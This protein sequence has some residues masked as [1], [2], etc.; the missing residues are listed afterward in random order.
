MEIAFGVLGG[1]G[2]FLYGMNLMGTGLQKAAGER[3]KKLIEILTNN[4][5][6]G[7]LVCTLVTMIIQ[8]SSATTV[9]VVGFVNA[10]LMTLSQAIGVIMG[11]N[12][13]T[14]VTAQLVAFK[15]TD[16]APIV[17]AIGVAIWLFSSNKRHKEI[18]EILIGFGIL[19]IGMDF[20]KHSLKPLGK[21]QAFKDLLISLNNPYLGILVGFGLTTIV[22]SSSASIG[23]LIALASQGLITIDIALPILFGDNIGTCVTA[24]LSSIGANKT[25]K[26]AAL[27]HLLF[28]IVGTLIFMLA[29]RYPIQHLVT[30]LTPND[31]G[32]Q[33]ANAHTFFNIANVVIQF[34]F[35]GFIVMAAKKLIPGEV[36]EDNTGLKYLDTRIIETP[37]IA[38]GQAAKEVLRMGK[39]AQNSLKM[40]K[41]SFFNKSEKLTHKVFEQEKFINQ[42]EKDIVQYL[43]ELSNADLTDEQQIKVT[44]LLNTVN[45]LERVGDHADNIAELAQYAIDNKLS[46]TDEALRELEMMFEKVEN[47]YRTALMAYKTADPEIARSV[48]AF[49]EDIDLMEKQLRSNHIER[50]NKQLCHPSS[51]IIFLDMISNLERV[52]DHASNIALAILDA[53]K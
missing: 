3:L 7:V 49:E 26:R 6:M 51:G 42:L 34:P 21:S 29:L 45:D 30:R 36:E 12:I 19:F 25:A 20:M 14:T 38:V 40:A 9:M 1:L 24:L 52:A 39:V 33:I 37:S 5:F 44:T 27:M 23:L 22:Q 10:G 46:F 47:S 8:S 13:G 50:L 41:E 11:A 35:A 31:V 15:L 53:L 48:I 32:R 28:N 16:I 18:A 2:L 4:R 17:V 43:V